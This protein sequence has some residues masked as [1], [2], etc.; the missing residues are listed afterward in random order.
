VLD[1]RADPWRYDELPLTEHQAECWHATVG[2]LAGA[3]LVPLVSSLEV[4]RGLWRRG[5][6]DRKLAER[7]HKGCGQVVA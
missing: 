1:G 2:H 4:R 7:L 6:R 3:G 5:G